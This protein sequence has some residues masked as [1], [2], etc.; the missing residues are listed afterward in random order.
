MS[1]P[2]P[3]SGSTFLLNREGKTRKNKYKKEEQIIKREEQTVD[4]AGRD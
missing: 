3:D 4:S 1:V 2:S